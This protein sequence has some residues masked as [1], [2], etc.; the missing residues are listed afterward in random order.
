MSSVAASNRA[1]EMWNNCADVNNPS[2][3]QN[4]HYSYKPYP[5][6]SSNLYNYQSNCFSQSYDYPTSHNIDYASKMYGHN[7]QCDAVVKTEPNWQNYP[8]NYMN[9]NVNM[10]MVNR[11]REMNYYAQQQYD[12]CAYDQRMNNASILDNKGEDSR[13]VNSPGQCSIPETSYGSPHS[14]SSHLKPAS[15]EHEDSPN[16]RALLTKPQTKKSATYFV[17]NEKAFAQEMQRMM[18][19]TNDVCDWE[20]TNEG[21][22]EKECN[23]S[24]FHGGF[25]TEG[26]TSAKSKGNVGGAAVAK[27]AASSSLEPS[28]EPCQEVTRVAAGGD[29]AN[30]AENKMAAAPDA[31][32]FYP[33]MKGV[34]GW[35]NKLI[36]F[37]FYFI[38]LSKLT[39]FSIYR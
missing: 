5:P 10:E 23:L 26:Q 15:P 33:W 8:G 20:K 27:E 1:S 30:Y 2:A 39:L 38:Y 7:N 37:F 14:T 6:V 32:G 9:D 3:R 28:A 4:K 24:Q 35:Y 19:N 34:A 11:W 29:T 13:T 16:L 22:P 18:F 17:K 25:E 12:N 31:Q 21:S 36:R